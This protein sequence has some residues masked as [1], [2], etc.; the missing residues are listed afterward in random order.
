MLCHCRARQRVRDASLLGGFRLPRAVARLGVR[1]GAGRG[2]GRYR[3]G[4]HLKEF[5]GRDGEPG[6][7]VKDGM[8]N[9]P[10]NSRISADFSFCVSL[11]NLR[12]Y[13]NPLTKLF[14]FGKMEKLLSL[15]LL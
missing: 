2:A 9:L 14:F 5:A 6:E 12:E 11:R 15:Q 10:Q 7:G 4:G 1:G 13:R 3:R 8:N